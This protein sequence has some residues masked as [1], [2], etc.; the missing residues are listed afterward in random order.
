MR[1]A[2][3]TTAVV[4]A[5]LTAGA[6]ALV[7]RASQPA[8]SLST[9]NL[10]GTVPAGRFF[11]APLAV[12]G[13]GDLHVVVGAPYQSRIELK[14]TTLIWPAPPPGAHAVPLVLCRGDEKLAE[15]TWLVNVAAPAVAAPL[16]L[17]VD[18]LPATVTAGRPF[19]A[20]LQLSGDAPLALDVRAADLTVRDG[21]LLWAAPAPGQYRFAITA[22]D[23]HGQTVTK[24]W[25]VTVL[26]PTAPPA[27]ASDQAPTDKT[28]PERVI[29]A[30]SEKPAP[31]LAP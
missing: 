27:A 5:F 25:E 16:A 8:P 20:D 28:P 10:P 24:L 18:A 26:A 29:P 9:A 17:G 4:L 30:P 2:P 6:A 12:T 1:S 19:A 11:A 15:A 21:R 14:G 3:R 23:S 7:W 31:P 22:Q 13:R